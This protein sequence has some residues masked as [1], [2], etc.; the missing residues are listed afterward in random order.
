MNSK[1]RFSGIIILIMVGI[2]GGIGIY[3]FLYARGYTYLTDSPEACVNCHSMN[4]QYASWMKSSHRSVAVC[5]DCH[6]PPKFFSKYY[7]KAINGF[8]HSWYFTTQTYPDNI[9][10]SHRT[11]EVLEESCRSCHADIVHAIEPVHNTMKKIT[12][13]RCHSRV[14]HQ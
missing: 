14:G 7:T 11:K 12:C 1:K 2:A 5:N 9:L 3:T 10:S 6:T 4:S 8:W 13:I